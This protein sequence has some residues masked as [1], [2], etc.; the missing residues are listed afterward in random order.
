MINKLKRK[1]LTIGTVFMFL[2]MTLLVLTMN[3][4]NYYEVTADADAVLDVLLQPNLPDFDGQTPRGNADDMHDFIPRNMSV[5]V[6][7]ESRFF[8]VM[9][10]A[11]DEV[12]QSDLSRIVS[13]DDDDV[14]DYIDQALN[15]SSARGF[16]GNFRY[17]KTADET[18]TR[19]LFLDCGR[20]LDSF[21]GFLWISVIVGLSGCIIIFVAFMLA[22]GKI[23]APIAESYEK[24]KRF[25]SDAGHEIKTP[26]TIINANVDLLESDGEKE[27]LTDI[28]QQTKR[29]TE[30]TNNLIFLSK[31]EEAEHTLQKIAFPLSDLVEETA[32]SFRALAASRSL[33]LETDIT[34]QM[35]MNGSP[36]AIR[37]L[38]SI[39]LENA[40]KYSPEGGA[41]T[42]TLAP[43]RKAAVL[44]VRNTAVNPVNDADLPHLFDRFYR[45]DTSR[46]SGT[47]GHGI[48]LSIAKAI[49]DAHGGAIAASTKDGQDFIIT[50]T[51][52]L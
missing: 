16:I 9:V 51:L 31:M 18:G 49:V 20:K 5:E 28:R 25:I 37:Q 38:V 33:Q 45:T 36:D 32:S 10:S 14:N 43:H 6:P 15:S 41:V 24:Q 22:V 35:T 50:V 19:I 21:T 42:L 13:V 34:P 52:P 46:N 3:L 2:L 26:L 17:A 29:L 47:G 1:F 44:M 30:L 23:V 40:V 12:L 11:D 48:G 39:L 4:V 27:E 7:Y 8:V